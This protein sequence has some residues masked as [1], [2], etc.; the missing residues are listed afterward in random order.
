M[1]SFY[2]FNPDS[3]QERQERE[4]MHP[5]LS[6][7]HIALREELGEEEYSCFYSAEKESFKP[8]MIP[9]QSYKPTWIQA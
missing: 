2:E 3:P 9:N 1:K 5:E 4:K 7:F 6:K 8:F